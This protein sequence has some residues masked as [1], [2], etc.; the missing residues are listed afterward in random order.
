[1]C[2]IIRRSRVTSVRADAFVGFVHVLV[3]VLLLLKCRH[4][5][6]CERPVRSCVPREVIPDSLRHLLHGCATCRAR[7]IFDECDVHEV[8]QGDEDLHKGQHEGQGIVI[9]LLSPVVLHVCQE[10]RDV[11]PAN[12]PHLDH[13]DH[14]KGPVP[15]EIAVGLGLYLFLLLRL[16]DGDDADEGEAEQKTHDVRQKPLDG[17]HRPTLQLKVVVCTINRKVCR[18]K[19]LHAPI[20]PGPGHSVQEQLVEDS[21]PDDHD[22]CE[23][24]LRHPTYLYVDVLRQMKSGTDDAQDAQHLSVERMPSEE[25]RDLLPEEVPQESLLGALARHDE[26]LGG[27]GQ[28]QEVAAICDAP[29][30]QPLLVQLHNV[31]VLSHGEILRDNSLPL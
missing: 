21:G 26:D 31:I 30:H 24:D 22:T 14:D 12:R 20:L 3:R 15:P 4:G 16:A 18:L 5:Q 27:N 11:T 13:H 7:P 25:E 6:I 2:D 1:M 9:A 23:D 8:P 10:R 28:I 29:V 19:V 17:L